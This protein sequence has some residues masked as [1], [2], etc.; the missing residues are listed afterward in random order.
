MRLAHCPRVFSGRTDEVGGGAGDE[1]RPGDL[2]GVLAEI[3][4]GAALHALISVSGVFIMCAVAWVISWYK[5]VADKGAPKKSGRGNADLA[6][7][8]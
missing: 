7:G 5:Q 1:R 3:G 6:G 4:G 2:F 8:G